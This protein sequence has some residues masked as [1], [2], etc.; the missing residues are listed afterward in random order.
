[1]TRDEWIAAMREELDA[2][3]GC[4]G[5]TIAEALALLEKL[6]AEVS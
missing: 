1:M 4:C 2:I 3:H 5:C 6:P